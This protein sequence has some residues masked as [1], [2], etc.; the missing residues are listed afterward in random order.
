MRQPR[1]EQKKQ[2]KNREQTSTGWSAPRVNKSLHA[3]SIDMCFI[4]LPALII[5]LC[6]G[7][8][9]SGRHISLNS[10]TIT[11]KASLAKSCPFARPGLVH[12]LSK[13]LREPAEIDPASYVLFDLVV[14]EGV[15]S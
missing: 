13:Y 9:Q 7:K 8:T 10:R 4:H 11:L 2:K 15:R 6:I 14:D 3:R 5:S 1:G 12:A